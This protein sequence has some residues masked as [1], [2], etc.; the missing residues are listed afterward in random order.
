M[1]LPRVSTSGGQSPAWE[2][3]AVGVCE[4][5]VVIAGLVAEDV[6]LAVLLNGDDCCLIIAR[7]DAVSVHVRHLHSPSQSIS[8]LSNWAEL[9][10]RLAVRPKHNALG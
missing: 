5:E 8:F 9:Y 1:W 7:H 6:V 3:A 4:E 10:I 2:R